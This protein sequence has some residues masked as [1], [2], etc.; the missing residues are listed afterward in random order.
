LAVEQAVLEVGVVV[1]KL[2][3]P[4]VAQEAAVAEEEG[5]SNLVLLGVVEAAA[6]V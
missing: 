4:D 2:L 1:P 3:Y 6:L 5:S